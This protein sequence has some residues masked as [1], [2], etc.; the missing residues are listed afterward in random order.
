[1]LSA[2]RS[3]LA[4]AALAAVAFTALAASGGTA[5]AEDATPA[6]T[7]SS[8]SSGSVRVVAGSEPAREAALRVSAM[9]IREQAAS[10]VMG[11]MPTTDIASLSDYMTRDGLG[12]FILM[13]AN[14]PGNEHELRAITA[15]LT[16]DAA[17]PPLIS[18]DQEGGDVSRLPW[19]TFAS[20]LTLKDTPPEQSE[21][22]FAA[23]AALLLRAGI[24]VNFGVVADV[25]DDQGMFIFRRELGTTPPA[26]AERVRAAAAGEGSAVLTTLKH[27]PGHGAA[28]GDSHGGIPTTSKTLQEW[29]RADA[30]P[31]TA[32]IEAGAGILMFG[33]LAYTAVDSA[34]ATLSAEWH[35]IARENLGFNG[36]T[37]TDDLGMLQGSGLAQYADPVANAVAA[38]TAGNDM[39]LAVAY[40]TPESAGRIVD[41]I[42][43]AVESGTL[44]EMR[45]HEAALRIAQARVSLAASGAGMVPCPD[46]APLG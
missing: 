25:T 30:V 7:A 10:I 46:C 45:L 44:P 16:T 20:A 21:D 12:G 24:G 2:R 26:S 15:A 9:S 40:T 33:H 41:G 38:V 42:V 3:L 18:V 22:A 29:E 36:I 23:R 43:A 35:R 37:I 31:F 34:P 28:A 19:D 8:A 39:I 14:I 1:M 6:S 13:G 32:G 27:F 5:R 4:G 11:H 17:F